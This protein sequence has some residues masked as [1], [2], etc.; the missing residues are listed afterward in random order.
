MLKSSWVVL[1]PWCLIK[2][3]GR[4]M[5]TGINHNLKNTY[6][7]PCL[8]APFNWWIM[9]PVSTSTMYRSFVQIDTTSHWSLWQNLTWPTFSGKSKDINNSP[10]LT[11]HTL[12]VLS[13]EPGQKKLSDLYIKVVEWGQPKE[14][15]TLI[16]NI[17]WYHWSEGDGEQTCCYQFSISCN[18]CVYYNIGVFC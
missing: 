14:G 16:N 6:W 12:A 5:V 7:S 4:K 13:C 18:I 9:V 3:Q 1:F 2:R 11:V 10:V 8:F 17:G 15:G